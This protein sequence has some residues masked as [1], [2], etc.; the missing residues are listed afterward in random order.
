M[1]TWLKNGTVIDGSGQAAFPADLLLD[2]DRI[3]AV[4][5]R[6]GRIEPQGADRIYDIAGRV[7]TPGFIDGHRHG[8]LAALLDN[9]YGE[10]ELA[11]G[12]T[13]VV[14]GNCGLTP[15][16]SMAATRSDWHRF[17]EPCL[18]P[19]P[20]AAAWPDFAA[21]RNELA[22]RPLRINVATQVGTGAIR[23]AVKGFSPAP[24]T[25]EELRQA[26][27]MLAAALDQ[28]ALGASMGIMYVPECYT[29]TDEFVELLRPLSGSDMLLSC[30]MRGEGNSL[31]SSVEEILSI[32]RQANV[33]LN[34][35]HFKA[36]GIRNWDRL[37]HQA[38]DVIERSDLDV[39]VDFYPYLGGSTTL[40]TLLPPTLQQGLT[41][42]LALLASPGGPELVRRELARSH[43]G[44]DSMVEAV[45]WDRIIVNAAGGP[46]CQP[47]LGL[48]LAEI[49]RRQACD[50]V[51]LLCRLLV[52][53]KGN[54]GTI[55]MSMS[56]SDVDAI[57]RLPYASVI[58]DSLYGRT[59]K[60]HPRL[61][62]A[63]PK[64]LRELVFERHVLTLEEAV[65][66]M[67][68]R[69][70]E[71]H[72]LDKRGQIRPGW[73]ADLNVFI[74]EQVRDQASYENPRQLATGMELV[75]VNGQPAWQDGKPAKPDAGRML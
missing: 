68:S 66:K 65:A 19:A 7:V 8:D 67:S 47:L 48:S 33:R 31:V 9:R 49:A 5:P 57:A 22:Q 14:N 23:T 11:Q 13:T 45:G 64:V 21:Y 18:G 71:R 4:L 53:E 61:Y 74:P 41:E 72:G 50:P 24:Y 27:H 34:I 25:A 12:I 26:Q 40:M 1:R 60:P 55:A 35:S 30:H 43:P 32:C 59:D 62:G 17:L 10:I 51:D 15:F 20:A 6:P 28:G 37:I 63:F 16:P 56:Q 58:S 69:G 36:V 3:E 2:G 75:L 73:I 38:I 39:G 42:T 52:E 54:V 70:A 29:R 44:W 46:E